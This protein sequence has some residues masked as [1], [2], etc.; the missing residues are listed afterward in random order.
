MKYIISDGEILDDDFNTPI[1]QP[2]IMIDGLIVLSKGDKEDI[3]KLLHRDLQEY[4][5]AGIDPILIDLYEAGFTKKECVI[6]LN[7]LHETSGISRII[8]LFY[9]LQFDK[10]KDK[11]PKWAKLFT[12]G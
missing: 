3:S 8:N 4:K 7:Y 5:M 6:I 9:T 2:T 10:I 11:I 1:Q 12:Y